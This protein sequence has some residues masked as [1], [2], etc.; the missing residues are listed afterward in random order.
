[1]GMLVLMTH[2]IGNNYTCI[3]Y[4]SFTS[5]LASYYP[6][7]HLVHTNIVEMLLQIDPVMEYAGVHK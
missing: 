1:M 2:C 6:G 4:T 3:M 7:S 5:A